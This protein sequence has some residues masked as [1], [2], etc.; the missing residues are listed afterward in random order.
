MKRFLFLLA[1]PVAA[2]S[3]EIPKF[4]NAIIANHVTFK[5]VKA[6][7]LDS[8]FFID[9]QNEEDGT[10]I[11]KPKGVCDCKN[12]D[13]NQLIVYVRVKDSSATF[14]GKFNLNYNYNQSR[15]GLLSNDKT[16]FRQLEY[17]KSAMSAPHNIFLKLDALVRSIS[18]QITYA[19]L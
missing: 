17:W 16:D 2:K 7:L 5:Q 4:S 18:Q 1:L 14:T 13:F 6:T 12:K 19:K 11:T 15:G 10:I 8:A 9:Q 3:Q